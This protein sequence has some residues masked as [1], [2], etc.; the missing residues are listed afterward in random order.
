MMLSE[1]LERREQGR[2][3]IVRCAASRDIEMLIEAFAARDAHVERATFPVFP[4]A[5]A[6]LIFHFGDPFLVG[7]TR[8]DRALP[9]AALLGPRG[10]HHWQSAGPRIEWLLVQLTP[11]GLRRLLGL[12][13]AE[14]WNR[15]FDLV[16]FWGSHA[17]A[18]WEQLREAHGFESRVAVA[19]A[20]LRAIDR[21]RLAGDD[22]ASEAGRLARAGRLRTIEQLGARLDVGPRCLRRRFAAEYGVGPKHFLSLM[23]F[24]RH[25]WNRHPL[26]AATQD[27]AEPEYADDSHAIREF[28]RFAGMTPG[29]YASAKATGDTLVFTGPH[30][31]IGAARTS[32]LI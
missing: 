30:T 5:R 3:L 7:E 15:E 12:P 17:S 18:L 1:G 10:E 14:A 16:D 8:A 20:A 19:N 23:R 2:D 11:L 32:D 24:G 28:R 25:L 9:R 22:A 29:A 13:F 6:E 26:T 31:V 21:T 27:D 4:T